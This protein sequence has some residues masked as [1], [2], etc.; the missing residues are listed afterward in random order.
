MADIT[1]LDSALHE[2][3]VFRSDILM[4]AALVCF[5][6]SAANACSVRAPPVDETANAIA[7]GGVFIRGTVIQEFDAA[8]Q[9]PEIIRAE[10]I[11]VGEGSPRDF[12]I[13]RSNA[14]FQRELDPR[15]P[16]TPCDLSGPTGFKLGHVFE[17]LVLEPARSHTDAAANGRWRF[18]LFGSS[19]AREPGLQALIEAAIRKGRFQARPPFS[20]EWGDQPPKRQTSPQ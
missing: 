4:A 17:R 3:L 2:G 11:Y 16:R 5:A 10:A 1:G 19:V 8:R 13:Y 15:T 14:E 6:P 18:A 20:A 12:V 7:E 9:Q